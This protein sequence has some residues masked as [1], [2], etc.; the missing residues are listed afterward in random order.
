MSIQ[1][2]P[3]VLTLGDLILMLSAPCSSLLLPC[4][5]S[6]L[7]SFLPLQLGNSL[8]GVLP[9]VL[10]TGNLNLGFPQTVQ[11]PI[12]TDKRCIT[13]PEGTVGCRKHNKPIDV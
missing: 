6:K 3:A 5:L 4:P 7:N 11:T 9:L 8:G 2:E 13:S 12:F 10:A 1:I